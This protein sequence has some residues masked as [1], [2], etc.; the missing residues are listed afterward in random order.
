M[1]GAGPAPQRS[2]LPRSLFRRSLA[3]ATIVLNLL[4]AALLAV[5]LQQ[6][7][8]QYQE[9]AVMTAQ[10][11]SI[12]LKEN[13]SATVREI[14]VALRTVAE[15]IVPLL[16]PTPASAP[17]RDAAI[18]RLLTQM[19]Q[20]QPEIHAIRVYDADGLQRYGRAAPGDAPIAAADYFTALRDHPEPGLA[21]SSPMYDERTQRW[22]V[23]V[24]RALR[25]DDGQFLG[26]LAAR[27]DLQR[28]A[29]AFSLIEVGPHGALTLTSSE[30]QVYARFSRLQVD[31]TMTGRH[32]R[33]AM[34]RDYV[35]TGQRPAAYVFR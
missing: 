30:E 18:A 23:I 12:A 19:Q 13:I 14:D 1:N 27:L 15:D 20:R 21:L 11:L 2:A 33:S 34:L 10:N 31:E 35:T 9:H 22:G 16:A 26:I 17:A 4:I 32:I 24:A 7:Y 6:S 25:S 5:F 3:S 8:R 28:L 29:S